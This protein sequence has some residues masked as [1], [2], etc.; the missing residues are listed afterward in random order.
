MCT[1][2]QT[3]SHHVCTSMLGH[4]WQVNFQLADV[5]EPC[6]IYFC[7]ASLPLVLKKFF[8]WF[9]FISCN[10]PVILVSLAANCVSALPPHLSKACILYIFGCF[11]SVSLFYYET[12]IVSSSGSLSWETTEINQC[13]FQ[14]FFA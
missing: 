8:L 13:T 12:Y 1:G 11:P 7:A 4:S 5:I 2:T 9:A 14:S 6:D 3:H 10:G